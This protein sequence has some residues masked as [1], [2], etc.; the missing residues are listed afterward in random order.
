MVCLIVWGYKDL[1]AQNSLL[2]VPE[3]NPGASIDYR[4][5]SVENP[6]MDAIR[7]SSDDEVTLDGLLDETSWQKAPIATGFTQR[8]PVDG[9]KPT[10]N[11]EARILYTDSHI[12]VGIMAFETNIDSMIGPLFRRDGGQTSD[13]V[14][15]AFDSYNDKRTAFAF[16]VNPRGVQTDILLFDDTNDDQLWDAV[17]EAEARIL[18]NG[19]SVEMKIPL[20]QLR[21]SSKNEIHTWGVNFVRSIARNNEEDFWSPT[22]RSEAGFVSKFGTLAGIRDL[23]EPR[24]L[25]IIPYTSARLTREPGDANNPYYK[26]NAWSANIGGDIKYGLTSDLTLTAT[27]NPDFGQV[28]ADPS[29]INLSAYEIYFP[30][31]RPFFLEGNDIFRFGGTN[32]YNTFGNPETFYSR[33]IGRAP[34]GSIHRFNDYRN[35]GVFIQ[36]SVRNIYQDYP[37]QTSIAAAAKV[38]GKTKSGWSIGVLDAYTLEETANY[39]VEQSGAFAPATGKYTV[40]PATNYFVSRVKKDINQGNTVAGGF[41]SAVN[42]NTNNTYFHNYLANSAYLGGVDL[43]HNWKDREWV[44][45]GTFSV[46]QVNGSVST[47]EALQ[48]EPQRFYQRVDSEGLSV[49]TNKTSLEGFA[50]ELSLKKSSGDHWTGSVTY[51]EVSPGY[52]TNEIGFERRADYRTIAFA[53]QY[54]E[55]DPKH[56]QY[57]E[58]WS[59]HLHGW[60][61]DGDRLYRNYNLGG[62][63]RFKNQWYFNANINGSFNR[64]EDRLT[65]G[66]PVMKYNDDINF[67]FNVGTDRSKM[68]SFGMGQFHRRDISNEYD[69]Y[70]WFDISVRPTTFIQ[71]SFEPELGFERDEDQYVRTIKRSATDPDATQTFGYRYIFADAITTNLVANIRLNW[72]FTPRMSLQTYLRP[73]IAT[74]KFN[75][76]GEFN[77]PGGFGF[78]RYGKDEGTLTTELDGSGNKTGHYLVD[79]DNDGTQ[80]FDFWRSDFTYRSIQGNA[81]FRWEYKPGSTFFLVWQQQR[82]GSIAA[83]NFEFNRDISGLFTSKPINVFLVK[84]SYWFGT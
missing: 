56:V 27:I 33:R 32:T 21:F 68:F 65:R 35:N 63:T 74:G 53:L 51:S 38:S 5:G 13:W 82:D 55:T 61:H 75:N 76:F 52:E 78:D 9:G 29:T 14:Y 16:G 79:I 19:W 60:N 25:E 57:Y 31:R 24:R 28:E 70:Y 49:D 41:F 39:T 44:A 45:S 81:V 6:V 64:L 67:N 71:F 12:Y 80:D 69:D 48:K 10:Q 59:Y 40:E 42:R 84:F 1:L 23:K 7:I 3:I 72:T 43:E 20:S 26:D 73:Y 50:T 66:G 36:D 83:G 18:D 77:N 11:T 22:L 8:T 4:Q 2:K 34:Q 17:W 58:L 37:D 46:S 62:Y 30:E 54:Q 47:I 15:V